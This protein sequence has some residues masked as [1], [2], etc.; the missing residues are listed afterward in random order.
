MDMIIAG[1]KM[2][3]VTA[4]TGTAAVLGTALSDT[5]QVPIAWLIG[6]CFAVAGGAFAAGVSLQS[7]KGR[8]KNLE[9][10]VARLEN[11]KPKHDKHNGD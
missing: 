6:G 2:V 5:T 10:A 4:V 1:M 11:R 9:D 3:G 7:V 8:L